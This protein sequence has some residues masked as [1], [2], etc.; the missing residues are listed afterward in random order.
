[1]L[2][3]LTWNVLSASDAVSNVGDASG[4]IAYAALGAL[5]VYRTGNLV[6]WFM[7]AEG[8][9]NAIMA[10]GSA[11]AVF[12]V[13]A[14][15]GTLPAPAVVGALAE[16]SFVIV[17]TG[18]AAIFLVFPSG[19]LPSPRWRPPAA[20]GLVLIGL[21][22][23]AFGVSA[24][25]VALPAPGGNSLTYPNPLAVRSLGPATWLGSLNALGVLFLL[26]LVA[27]LISLALRYRRGDQ[28]LR[29]QM[30][31]LGL[32]IAGVLACQIVAVLAIAAGRHGR[33]ARPG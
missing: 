20:A 8:V 6:G 18:L 4:A 2:T 24:R 23:A 33:A 26:V 13:T 17:T 9:G 27:S 14:H 19:R 32:A 1:M 29:Q 21:T 22:L 3:G 16:S 7:L 5:I 11:Y 25:R 31:W 30:K 10:A 28:R 12:G 15:P